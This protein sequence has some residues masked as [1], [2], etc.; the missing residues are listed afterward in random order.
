MWRLVMFGALA[1][2]VGDDEPWGPVEVEP[3]RRPR[4]V[5]QGPFTVTA[6]NA[7]PPGC[8]AD[9]IRRPEDI[10]GCTDVVGDP[11][12]VDVNADTLYGLG[13]GDVCIVGDEALEAMRGLRTARHGAVRIIGSNAKDL[14]AMSCLREA[15]T[16]HIRGHPDLV[17]TDGL[18]GLRR[19]LGLSISDSPS[20]ERLSGLEGLEM[21][22]HFLWLDDLPALAEIGPMDALEHTPQEVRLAGLPALEDTGGLQIWNRGVV[23]VFDLG[24]VGS[25]DDLTALG[26]PGTPAYTVQ[27]SNSLYTSLDGFRAPSVSYRLGLFSNPRLTDV[28]ALEDLEGTTSVAIRRA[29]SLPEIVG[30]NKLSGDEDARFLFMEN[31]SLTRI[32]GFHGVE[33]AELLYVTDSARLETLDAFGHLTTAQRV[34]LADL[35]ALETWSGL[36]ALREI[37]TLR[38]L[39]LKTLQTLD[40]RFPSLRR[41]DNLV[42]EDVPALD[43]CSVHRLLDQLQAPPTTVRAPDASACGG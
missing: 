41:V 42:I 4:Q 34:E 39:R 16:L 36:P 30:S 28:S 27:I 22:D 13:D 9:R 17:S 40:G 12:R 2:C 31:A 1:A 3:C 14:A 11:E 20:L 25:G 38:L 32:T 33:D 35:D 10:A 8:P 23:S 26:L 6:G 15:G 24:Q 29:E 21:L 5:C 43:P 37:G 18:D 7:V 19:T